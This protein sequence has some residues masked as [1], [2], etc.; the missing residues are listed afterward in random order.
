MTKTPQRRGGST[1]KG[2]RPPEPA[3]T[4][5]GE[6]ES[7]LEPVLSNLSRVQREQVVNTVIGI[8]HQE[9]YSGPLPHPR[10]FA[11]FEDVLPGGAERIL[12]M[13]E[14]AHDHNIDVMKKGQ[15]CDQRYRVL[16]MWL[17][18]VALLVL[19]GSAVYAGLHG[20][21]ILAGLL[22]GTGVLSSIGVFVSAHIKS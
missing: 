11:A 21:N 10:H 20:N 6:V 2:H 14:R 1:P 5:E 13:A 9:A 16:G 18:F 3:E 7:R 8:V 15:V 19:V 17:G 12:K 4:I 22:L